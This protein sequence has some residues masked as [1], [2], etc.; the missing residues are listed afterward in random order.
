MAIEG[1]ALSTWEEH[2]RAQGRTMRLHGGLILRFFFTLIRKLPP[3][4]KE[5]IYYYVFHPEDISAEDIAAVLRVLES[6]G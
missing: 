5:R 4:L 2:A 3:R 6:K 1:P